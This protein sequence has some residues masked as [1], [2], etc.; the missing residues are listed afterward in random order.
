[1]KQKNILC[2]VPFVKSWVN[3][4][5]GFRNCCVADPQIHSTPDQSFDEWWTS[6]ELIN[7]RQQLI[8]DTLPPQCHRCTLKESVQQESIRLAVNKSVD[9]D[10]IDFLWPSRWDVQLDNKCNLACWTCSEDSSS[11]ILAH[12]KKINILPA[13]ATNSSKNVEKTWKTTKLNILK[14]YKIHDTVTLTILGG[15]PLFNKKFLYFLQELID[16]N[17]SS[18]TNLEIHT[19]GT[20]YSTNLELILSKKLWNHICMF[21]SV[22]AVGHKAAWLRYGSTWST[23]AK[24][25]KKFQELVSYTEVQCV[26]SLLNI[27][28]LVS[29][30]AFCR[31][32][33]IKLQITTLANPVFMRLEHWYLDKTLLCN[34]QELDNAG[35]INYYNLLGSAPD[36]E[37]Y[38]KLRSYI[39]SFDAIRHPLKNF[40]V[41]LATALKLSI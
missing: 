12:K 17:L 22:D 40:D 36:K 14:S 15:E 38:E 6:N 29:L 13:A 32:Q 1:M 26:L 11:L 24:N 20:F 3:Q 33:A 4:D 39:T 21:V 10:N 2:A 19:N 34:K 5:G 23:V 9:F 35:F 30:D 31:Q 41:Q 16:L 28:D 37:M 18:R 27:N 8:A 25:I 7:F